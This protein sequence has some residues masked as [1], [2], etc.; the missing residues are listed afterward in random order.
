M[1]KEPKTYYLEYRQS[2]GYVVA[3]HEILPMTV[4]EGY[5][6]AESTH[7]APGDEFEYWIKIY[8]D[9]VKDGKV[10]SHAAVRQAPPAQEM[11]LRLA[12]LEGNFVQFEN[13][14]EVI[15]QRVAALEAKAAK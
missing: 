1:D 13:D 5:A 3:I 15:E 12:Q 14:K 7:F 9:E 6:V 11:L 10:T 2:D 8:V 4:A